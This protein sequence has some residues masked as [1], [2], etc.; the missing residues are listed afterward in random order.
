MPYRGRVF[1]QGHYYHIFNRGVNKGQIFFNH[2][3][4]MYCIRLMQKYQEKYG[5]ATIAYCLMPNHYHLLLRQ[6]GEEPISRFV[7]VLF[8]AYV[9]A[10]NRQQQRIGVLFESRFRH[11]WVDHEE[12]LLHLCRYIHLN[13]VISQLAARPEDW[14]YSNY[15]EWIGERDG[16][17]KDE[18][19]IL[20]R[21][22]NTDEYRYFVNDLQNEIDVRGRL[23]KYMWD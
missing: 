19:F 3:N 16:L 10:V 20:E 22:R 13:P 5:T 8:N 6:E 14:P 15:L 11:V 12:Y 1:A 23:Q 18:A 7:N 17:L 9:Q 21:F 4:Y 2:D